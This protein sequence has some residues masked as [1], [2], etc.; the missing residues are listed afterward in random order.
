MDQ[1]EKRQDPRLLLR[2]P[3]R[4]E[5]PAVPSY[6]TL[7]FT[8]NVSRSGL[9][10]EA[11]QVMAQ[12][13]TT[14]LRMLTGTRMAS[15]DAAGGGRGGVPPRGVP[16]PAPVRGG[17]P[18]LACPSAGG[19]G[20]R[21]DPRQPAEGGRT[22]RSARP[23]GRDGERALHHRRHPPELLRLVPFQLFAPIRRKRCAT[24][25]CC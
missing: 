7:G 11:P 20:D 12:G 24:P 1:G 15:P 5:G 17:R 9:L 2:M 3:V 8:R 21:V 25:T 18:R 4:C 23:R 14:H 10:L 6:R 22:A 16:A 13:A 19:S